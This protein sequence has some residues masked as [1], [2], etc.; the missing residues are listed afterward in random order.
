MVL[1]A[2]FTNGYVFMVLIA[3]LTSVTWAV[4]YLSIIINTFFYNDQYMINPS[5]EK[6]NLIGNIQNIEKKKHLKS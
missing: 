4:Y 3:I 1:S 6:L 5:L 2:T